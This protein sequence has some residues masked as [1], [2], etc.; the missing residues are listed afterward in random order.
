MDHSYTRACSSTTRESTSEG[1]DFNSTCGTVSPSSTV[2]SEDLRSTLKNLQNQVENL[3]SELQ[4]ASRY[5]ESLENEIKYYESNKFTIDKIKDDNAAV[6]FYTGFQSYEVFESVCKYLEGK[7]ERLQYWRGKCESNDSKIYQC[8]NLNKPGP[9]RKMSFREEFFM[10]LI[11]VRVGLFVRDLADRF[12]IS[13]CMFSKTFT[14]LLDFL[15]EELPMLFP[16]PSQELIR[17]NLPISFA[18]Y[19]TTRVIIDCTEVRIE[20]PSAMLAQSETWSNYKH[21]NTYK[22]L[23]GVAPTGNVIFVSGVWGGRASDKEITLKSGILHLLQPGDN[24]MAD[25]GFEIED[26]LPDNVSLNIPPFKGGKSQ[27][28]SAE[29]EE[30]MSIASV[31]IHVE[32]AIGRIKIIIFWMEH[33]H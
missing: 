14:T 2:L 1:E 26:I 7:A 10:V 13:Q 20:V 19:P 9:K 25:R 5:I 3:E 32:R 30:T 4:E 28:S 21:F 22:A 23:V 12:E 24:V 29:V 6:M 31:R 15:N 17:K 16:F 33:C 27:L 11:R 8:N 18:D